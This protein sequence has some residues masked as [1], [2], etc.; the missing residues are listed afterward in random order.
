MEANAAPPESPP[1]P[2][3]TA[4]P[5]LKAAPT[6]GGEDV[7][8]AQPT[9]MIRSFMA[10]A[11]P[12]EENPVENGAEAGEDPNDSLSVSSNGLTTP[13]ATPAPDPE[14]PAVEEPTDPP[15]ANDCLPQGTERD[16]DEVIVELMMTPR[17]AL[18]VVMEACYVPEDALI[19]E[20]EE[21]LGWQTPYRE[22][23]E[24]TGDPNAQQVSLQ[25]QYLSL[26][27]NEKYQEFCLFDSFIDAPGEEERR[28][29]KNYYAVPVDGGETLVERQEV[30]GDLH[31]EAIREAYQA[32]IE[33]YHQATTE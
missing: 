16:N 26:S 11:L 30:E 1:A 17:E 12:G 24:P 28:S 20:T 9:A 13:D 21:F 32:G 4:A 27:A 23:G 14:S 6:Q 8:E 5:T 19:V 22:V 18:D 33:A 15:P 2:Q 7:P 29:V 10:T 31:D 3:P 25:L